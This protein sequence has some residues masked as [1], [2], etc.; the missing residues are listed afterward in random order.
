MEIKKCEFCGNEYKS[1]SVKSKCCSLKCSIE[2]RNKEVIGKTFGR[3]KV[4]SRVENKITSQGKKQS[5]WLCQ[6]R[7]GKTCI[8]SYHSLSTGNTKSCGCLEFDIKSKIHKTHGMKHTRLYGIWC[9]IKKRCLN[10]KDINFIYYGGRGITICDEWKNDFKTFYDWSIANGYKENLTIDRIDVNGNY[11]A[12]N[13]RWATYKEQNRNKRNSRM[14]TF[15][16]ETHCL[17]EW[18]EKIGINS[19][20]LAS[21]LKKSD[22]IESIF[23]KRSRYE[24]F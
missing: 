4:L 13:C 8:V 1:Y 21:R 6:C 12:S 17:A 22:Q 9:A 11:E 18:A 16:G 19:K 5:M 20:T 2:R 10:K 15:N 14:I 23:N 24:K 3:L 7:C